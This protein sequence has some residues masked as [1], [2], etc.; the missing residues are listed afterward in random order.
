MYYTVYKITNIINNKVY[1][2]VH[3][4]SN[5]DDNYMGSGLNIKRAMKKYGIENFK[6][7][8][9][10][11]FENEFDMFKM[12]SQIVNSDFIKSDNTYN[13]NEGGNGGWSHINNNMTS[14]EKVKK[15]KWLGKEFG[16]QGG[17]WQDINKRLKI[18]DSIPIEKR[19]EIGKKLGDSFGGSNR[20]KKEDIEKR[21]DLI[22]DI[23]LLEYGWVKLVSE[24]LNLT[25]SQVRRFIR[26]YYKG[27]FFQ[28][29]KN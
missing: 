10:A 26:K 2:G 14:E 20:L 29:N 16:S 9:L 7:E 13:I 1:I 6:K 18:L 19:K 8:Y 21:L 11:I 28:R 17:S 15:G 23:N 27:E 5:L 25:H 4:T 12:E 24:K 22:K 3:K